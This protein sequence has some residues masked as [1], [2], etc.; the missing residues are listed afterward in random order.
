MTNSCLVAKLGKFA[1][2]SEGDSAMLEAL[3]RDE[4]EYRKDQLIQRRG[5]PID[6]M[7]VVKS[8]WLTSFSVLDDG[9]R[10]L[11]R[12]FFSGDIVDLS[13]VALTVSQ[14]DIK[15]LTP[16]VLCPFP[17]SGLEP[18]FHSSPRLTALL[19]SM[20]VRENATLLGR[21]RAIGRFNAY[22]RLCYLILELGSRLRLAAGHQY[23]P[24][25]F[26]IP[27][28]QS[29]IA[30]LLGLTNVYVSKTMSR[31]EKDGLIERHGNRIIICEPKRMQNICEFEDSEQID[32]SWFPLR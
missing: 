7:F 17:K 24:D 12:L 11:L 5:N 1:S 6:E 28:T 18:L 29:D 19:F 30:D 21:I 2:L 25:G 31:I 4:R 3:E 15:A 27:L 26:R 32:T 20:T 8:G 23:A 10:Q 22:E 13:N 9:R 16:A 14:H